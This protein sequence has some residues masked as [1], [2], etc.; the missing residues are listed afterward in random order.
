MN[1]CAVL[2][3]KYIVQHLDREGRDAV[4]VLVIIV[5][6]VLEMKVFLKR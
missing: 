6:E 4:T 3:T 2:C 1:E 5:D